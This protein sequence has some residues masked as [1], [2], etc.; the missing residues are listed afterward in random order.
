M[1]TAIAPAGR[2]ELRRSDALAIVDV[3]NDFIPGGSLAVPHGD[4]IVPVLNRYLGAFVA[5]GLG[6]FA[7]RDWHP[8]DHCSFR[9]QGGI[10]PSHCVA[11][12]AG[13]AFAPTLALP[14]SAT[15]ISKATERDRDAYSGFAGTDLEVRLR[16]AGITRVFV[17]GLATDYCVLNTVRDARALGFDVVLLADAV[18]AVNVTPGDG[19]RALAEMLRLGA[20]SLV[21]GHL[22]A[23]S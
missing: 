21:F 5:A 13:A 23:G 8:A 11:G 9:A 15:I 3:Q 22:A 14:A 12:T 4:E 18:A 19:P 16:K 17:G 2:I 6:V 10:W 1:S 7:T 20:R